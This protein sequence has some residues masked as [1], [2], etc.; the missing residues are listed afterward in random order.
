MA[1]SPGAP[2]TYDESGLR[3]SLPAEHFRICD[4]PLYDQLKSFALKEMDF[5]WLENNRI[6]LVE[7]KDFR[8][9]TPQTLKSFLPE[10]HLSPSR[11][12]AWVDKVTDAMLILQAIWL[13]SS[14]GGAFRSQV[15]PWAGKPKP[16]TFIIAICLP[17]SLV[18]HQLT[19]RDKIVNRLKGRMM[20]GKDYRFSFMGYDELCRYYGTRVSRLP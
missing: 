8:Q 16:L 11:F 13:D 17:Q 5:C 10:K 3:F 2:R 18:Q 1:A 20:L 14:Q 12:L 19:L 15:P 6:L 4:I 7:V 9:A